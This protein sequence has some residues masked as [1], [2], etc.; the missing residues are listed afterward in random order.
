M[1]QFKQLS[2]SW[3]RRVSST[4]C[5]HQDIATTEERYQG[6]WNKSKLADYCWTL[7]RDAPDTNQQ[8]NTSNYVEPN[9]IFEI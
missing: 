9:I 4:R 5:G 6:N 1:F 2:L 8:Q 7:Q 3:R